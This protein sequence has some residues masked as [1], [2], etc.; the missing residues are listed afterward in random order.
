MIAFIRLATH[1]AFYV[2]CAAFGIANAQVGGSLDNSF[3]GDGKALGLAISGGTITYGAAHALQPD[4][5]TIMAGSCP[6]SGSSRFCALRLLANGSLDTT[7]VGPFGDSG[8]FSLPALGTTSDSTAAI[9][10]Q[11]DGRILVAGSCRSGSFTDFCVVRL[12]ANGDFDNTFNGNGRRTLI[13]P[14]TTTA[15]LSDMAQQIDGKIVLVGS[16]NNGGDNEFCV[17]R[18]NADGSTDQDFDGNDPLDPKNGRFTFNISA[19]ADT[20]RAVALQTNGKIVIVGDCGAVARFCVA[21]LNTDGSFDVSFN[22][23]AGAGAGRFS[24]P[25]IGEIVDYATEVA[26]Q[27]DGK[28]LIAGSCA[29]GAATGPR[30]VF[31]AARLTSSGTYDGDFDGPLGNGNG[32]FGFEA[33]AGSNNIGAMAVQGDGNIVFA[34]TCDNGTYTDFCFARLTPQGAFD[35][36]FDGPAFVGGG[37]F[38]IAMGTRNDVLNSASIS[39]TGAITV[40]GY[41]ADPITITMCAAR[42]HP[43]PSPARNCSFDI[44]GD[45]LITATVDSLIATRIALGI[46]GDAVLNGIVFPP[47]APRRDWSAI[48]QYLRTH[49][50]MSV[51]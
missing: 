7:F 42:L 24:L 29:V 3:S 36:A 45:G 14:G 23:P 50:A 19:E 32:R 10:L 30:Y 31:C 22:S 18:L 39:S 6:Q 33:V 4:G 35:L 48:S 47:A 37:G 13:I 9:A 1:L 34:G 46:R 27:R 16:C 40:S 44:D 49:C 43:G 2:L 12:L 41:C 11:P 15:Q 26:I 25:V 5:K 20:A 51:Y 21:R 28:I 38:I 8:S 17:A